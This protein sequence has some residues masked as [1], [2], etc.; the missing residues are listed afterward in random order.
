M[1]SEVRGETPADVDQVRGVNRAAFDRPQEGALV[2]ALRERPGVISLV[3]ARMG[4]VLGHILF[5]P[6]EIVGAPTP[7]RVAGLGPMAVLPT[8]QR[9]GI[10]SQLVRAGLEA[11]RGAA[12]DA[13]VVL[14]HPQFYPRF[15]FAPASRFGLRSEY[16]VPDPVFMALE[17]RPGALPAQGGLVK[18]R[19]EFAAA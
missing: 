6:V 3:A 12:Y 16:D 1:A 4:M 2:D 5:S 13:V 17:L 19:P 9:A 11:C 14:G 7:A 10:G 18:Y 15:G 8:H